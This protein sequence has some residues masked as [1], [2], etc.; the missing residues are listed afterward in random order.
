[1]RFESWH[2]AKAICLSQLCHDAVDCAPREILRI[3]AATLTLFKV[4]HFLWAKGDGRVLAFIQAILEEQ[5]R[6]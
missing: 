1:M 3:G 6:G 2:V 4:G 5:G